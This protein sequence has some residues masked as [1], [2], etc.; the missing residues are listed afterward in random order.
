MGEDGKPYEAVR[1][2][3]WLVTPMRADTYG[4]LSREA[5]WYAVLRATANP[6]YG[7]IA[8]F[9]QSQYLAKER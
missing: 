9:V 5:V 4:E 8:G 1:Y 7:T 2:L 6:E 3:K